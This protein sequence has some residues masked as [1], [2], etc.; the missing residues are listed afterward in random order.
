MQKPGHF[1]LQG[2]EDFFFFFFWP[3]YMACRISVPQPGIE[4]KP[5]AVKVQSPNHLTTRKFPLSGGFF[6]IFISI[7]ENL[8]GRSQPCPHTFNMPRLAGPEHPGM[9]QGQGLGLL[10]CV[11]S[12]PAPGG[13]RRLD[14]G[15]RSVGPLVLSSAHSLLCLLE[16]SSSLASNALYQAI[17]C[18]HC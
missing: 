14:R 12:L 6:S 17:C 9:S 4:P 10:P 5:L 8:S 11:P 7:R 15:S 18:L 1:T 13:A 16:P 2:W 3:R